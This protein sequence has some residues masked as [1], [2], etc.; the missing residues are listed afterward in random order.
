MPPT[1][2]ETG[3]TMFRRLTHK[4]KISTYANC[5]SIRLTL[6]R[7]RL[8]RWNVGKF[9]MENKSRSEAINKAMILNEYYCVSEDFKSFSKKTFLQETSFTKFLTKTFL[10]RTFW[11]Q[12][13]HRL[14]AALVL[15]VTIEHILKFSKLL[16][17]TEPVSCY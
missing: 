6:K 9:L 3:V 8:Q 5:R 11:S 7:V 15:L 1:V 10:R 17:V 13:N 12:Q 14:M 2:S 16:T 4:L